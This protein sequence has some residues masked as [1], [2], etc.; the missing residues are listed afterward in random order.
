MLHVHQP[1][2]PSHPT[3]RI[4]W[5][6]GSNLSHRVL[7][8]GVTLDSLRFWGVTLRDKDR[9]QTPLVLEIVWCTM[10]GL[11][12][13]L[14]TRPT[15]SGQACAVQCLRKVL[16]CLKTQPKQQLDLG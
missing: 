5:M 11:L 2:P 3:P 6:C 7:L 8:L 4:S 9:C 12:L 14:L 1:L 15:K 16:G 10:Q 13:A